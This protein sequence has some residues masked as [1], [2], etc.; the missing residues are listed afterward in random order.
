M[1]ALRLLSLLSL[2]LASASLVRAQISGV[3]DTTSTPVPG[4]GHDYIDML[5]E[6][7]NPADGSLSVRI[8]LPLPPGRKVMLP[9]SFTYDSNNAWFLYTFDAPTTYADGSPV[10]APQAP[11]GAIGNAIF[12][13]LSWSG[14]STSLPQ[15][16]R[17]GVQEQAQH[18]TN[19]GTSVCGATTG[20]VFRDPSGGQHQ[21]PLSHIYNEPSQSCLPPGAQYVELDHAGDDLY[22]ATLVN[23]TTQVGDTP[24]PWYDGDPK[25]AGLDGTVYD[26][27]P[28]QGS[29]PGWGGCWSDYTGM[30][31]SGVATSIEDSNGNLVTTSSTSPCTS[32]SVTD[33]LQR[34]VLSISN[35]GYPGLSGSGVNVP[36]TS[37]VSVAGIS[38]P[39][40]AT[41]T[42]IGPSGL[43]T[44][45]QQVGSDDECPAPPATAGAVPPG[46]YGAYVGDTVAVVSQITLPNQ[47]AYTFQYDAVTGFINKITYPSGGYVSYTW[48]T[49]PQAAGIGYND[50]LGGQGECAYIYNTPA[51]TQRNVSF[52][53]NTIALTQT[54][55]YS[56]TWN[57]TQSWGYQWAAK[58][59][60]VTTQD[61][62]A[63]TTSK[64]V[65]TYSPFQLS[66][67]FDTYY[68]NQFYSLAPLE[69][70]V[71]A[72]GYAP[73]YPLLRTETKGWA[74]QYELT[75]DLVTLD[76]GQV[77]GAFNICRHLSPCLQIRKS[78][79]SVR[80][81]PRVSARTEP[82]PPATSLRP[83]KRNSPTKVSLT[84]PSFQATLRFWTAPPESSPTATD[85]RRRKQ[86]ILT[87]RP[88]S[89]P[90][91]PLSTMRQ[92]IRPATTIAATPPR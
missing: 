67:I 54:F 3:T 58:Q 65:Y 40:T 61:N 19:D 72:Y 70:T 59:T 18:T 37:T 8:S 24:V 10:L 46:P 79:T 86:I 66:T 47:T 63:R 64:T 49:N 75:C 56:T 91:Q 38:Q 41:W 89:T 62:I 84:R 2:I 21:L 4:A 87:T 12:G 52:D 31:N 13:A 50:R 9:F 88:R 28:N 27:G 1:R 26:F 33:T 85:Q 60:T 92:I 57:T 90:F 68:T 7:V 43:A 5:N 77:S 83:A 15:L 74:D 32:L 73:S 44:S 36:Q 22:Q 53:G 17:T 34:P 11:M 42:T 30:G 76:N 39:Y 69:A 51:I 23:P 71:A 45:P 80:S 14:W 82:R 29:A 35:Y 81:R 78:M 6:T 16:S 20:Y 48:G 25:V 55:S